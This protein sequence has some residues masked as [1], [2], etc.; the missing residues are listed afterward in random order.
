MVSGW[1]YQPSETNLELKPT[2]LNDLWLIRGGESEAVQKGTSLTWF[3]LLAQHNS[4]KFY[5]RRFLPKLITTQVIINSPEF[6]WKFLQV[7]FAWRK[8]R[9][10]LD[11]LPPPECDRFMRQ[12][13]CMYFKTR[14]KHDCT[15]HTSQLFNLHLCMYTSYFFQLCQLNKS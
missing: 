12:H 9:V 10:R 13:E 8:Q 5:W 3:S 2:T 15:W 11:S 14:L 1:W 7:I 4:Y 6:E